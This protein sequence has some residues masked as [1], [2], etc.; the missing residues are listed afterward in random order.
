[1]P[2]TER[3][4]LAA[5]LSDGLQRRWWSRRR[6]PLVQLLRPL[7]GLV[8]VLATVDR[9]L[10]TSQRQALRAPVLVVGNY[11]LGG[12]GKTPTTIALIEALRQRGWRPGVVSRGH[13]R[14]N[15]SLAVAG[16]GSDASTVGDEPLLIHRRTG[17]PLV[18]GRDRQAAARHLLERFPEVDLV[19]A[20]DG[21][22]HWRLGREWQLVVFDR[23][24]VG[25]GLTLPAGPLRQAL[26]PAPP[27]RTSVLY[28]ADRITTEWPGHLAR[29]RL[30][31]AAALADWWAGKTADP[32][33]LSRLVEQSRQSPVLAVAG[34]AEPARFFDMLTQL[35]CQL[36]PCPLPDHAP[37]NPLPWPAD[38]PVVLMTEKDAAKLPPQALPPGQQAWVVALDFSLP[39]ALVDEIDHAL[40][41]PA[42]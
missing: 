28:N 19:I 38:E 6:G 35:G 30:G 22:Q 2:T 21:L 3:R 29:R 26:P 27:A 37:M 39:E 15:A 36:R 24:G 16:P 41:A 9:H 8:Q 34:L 10:K 32:Q 4:G 11:V 31:G 20:D 18:V 17:V 33:A 23:R 14:T 1:V 7:A 13:G 5:A 40:R 25:N 42:H 12:A